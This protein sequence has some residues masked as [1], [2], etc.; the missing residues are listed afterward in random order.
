MRELKF[1][2]QL[3]SN[4]QVCF[5]GSASLQLQSLKTSEAEAARDAAL[6]ES[7]SLR[8]QLAALASRSS[9]SIVKELRGA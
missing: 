8:S 3:I 4:L 2:F 1:F 7:A 6:K 5:L 9:D